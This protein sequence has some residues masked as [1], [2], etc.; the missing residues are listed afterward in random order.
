MSEAKDHTHSFG[1]EEHLYGKTAVST[2]LEKGKWGVYGPLKYCY[3]IPGGAD[4]ANRIM[5]AAPKKFFKRAVKRNLLKRLLRESYR[6]NKDILEIPG[7]GCDLFFFYNTKEILSFEQISAA[8]IEVLMAV[9]TKML[10]ASETVAS[11]P[12]KA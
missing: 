12:D 9:R 5:V 8:V 11:E 3:L 4:G 10:K 6:L 1:K 7:M 2:L